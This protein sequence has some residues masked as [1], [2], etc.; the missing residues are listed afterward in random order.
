VKDRI[1]EAKATGQRNLPCHAPARTPHGWII[2]AARDLMVW[3]KLI[4]FT[5]HPI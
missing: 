1:R 5:D 4:G 2:M 3:T